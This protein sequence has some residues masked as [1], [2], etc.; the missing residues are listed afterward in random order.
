MRTFSLRNWECKTEMRMTLFRNIAFT[1][2]KVPLLSGVRAVVSNEPSPFSIHWRLVIPCNKEQC[3][4]NRYT[5]SNLSCRQAYER[6][7]GSKKKKNH[8]NAQKSLQWDIFFKTNEYRLQE[9]FKAC[10]GITMH[11]SYSWYGFWSV[12]LN[13][14]KFKTCTHKW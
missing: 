2:D 7:L 12:Y 9:R 10:F 4:Y 6:K 11:L 5:K 13:I 3:L 8:T 1:W 14:K